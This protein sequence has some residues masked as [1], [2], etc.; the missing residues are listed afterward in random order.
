MLRYIFRRL[1]QIIPVMLIVSVIVFV[2]IRITP[3]DPVQVMMGES[4]DPAVYQEL[5]AKLGLDQPIPVQYVFWLGRVVQGDLGKSI[6]DSSPVLPEI[7]SRL[8]ATIE[9]AIAALF[10]SLL[11]AIPLGIISAVRP[12][13]KV[14]WLVNFLSLIGISVPNF[15]LGILLILFLAYYFRIFKPDG[16]VALTDDLWGNL[17]HLVLPAL[18]LGAAGT[19]LNMRLIRS[20][21]L[22]VLNQDYIRTARAKGLPNQIVVWKHAFRNALVP[23]ATVIGLQIGGLLEGAV[24]TETIFSWP[25]I[26][27]LAVNSLNSLDYPMVQGIVL[28]TALVYTLV[29][30]I[31]DISYA[32]LDPRIKYD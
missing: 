29:N 20:N 21:M 18:T 2:L 22:E 28:F 17:Q 23:L 32:Y 9:L 27:Q 31:V 1:I 13:S 4:P 16:Y 3:G 24:I 12:N 8:P 10:V 26:G 14:D 19:A 25:G 6:R 15:L 7:L 5:R 11:I 30:L